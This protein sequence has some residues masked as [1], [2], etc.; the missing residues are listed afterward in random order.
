MSGDLYKVYEMHHRVVKSIT[1]NCRSWLYLFF[2]RFL[3]GPLKR[4]VNRAGWGFRIFKMPQFSYFL[5]QY[6]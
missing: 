4:L 5:F 6:I 2:F 3:E 1:F